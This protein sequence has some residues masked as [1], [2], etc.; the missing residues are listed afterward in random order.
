MDPESTAVIAF[1][2]LVCA[3]YL[4]FLENRNKKLNW[5]LLLCLVVFVA[6]WIFTAYGLQ[7]IY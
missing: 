5:L 2:A 3:A 7:S 4:V 6:A 1:V